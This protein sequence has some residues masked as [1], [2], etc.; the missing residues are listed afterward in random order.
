MQPL[1]TRAAA[2]NKTGSE[3]CRETIRAS[4]AGMG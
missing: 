1:R 4:L 2:T 3:R